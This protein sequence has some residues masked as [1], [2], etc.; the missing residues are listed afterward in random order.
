MKFMNV[1]LLSLASAAVLT[2]VITAN[3]QHSQNRNSPAHSISQPSDII[4]DSD[5]DIDADAITYTRNG[6]PMDAA[7]VERRKEI[8]DCLQLLYKMIPAT[9]SDDFAKVVQ[10][11]APHRLSIE[12]DSWM[13]ERAA[14]A[15]G[16]IGG[17]GRATFMGE[18]ALLPSKVSK[19][20]GICMAPGRVI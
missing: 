19:A 6:T 15:D 10:Y 18:R 4:M 12:E 1:H 3:S 7:R 11:F 16:E 5:G 2:P 8:H 13:Q 20:L 17:T 9:E 14:Q